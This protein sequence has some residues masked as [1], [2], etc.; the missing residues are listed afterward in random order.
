MHS[1]NDFME[2]DH[3]HCDDLFADVE[4]AVASLAWDRA[5]DAFT[6]FQ[7][8]MQQ[9]FAAEEEILFPAFVAKSGMVGGPTQVMQ[10]EHAQMNALLAQAK[11]A[12]SE[13]DADEY[14][15]LADTLLIMMQQHNMKEEHVLYPMCDEH[16][17]DQ[18]DSLL[19]NL[20][21]KIQ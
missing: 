13:R 7:R 20:Q 18:V 6:R 10:E 4:Q 16:L 19:P 14:E 3:R 11:A 9:H 8:A 5:T 2:S 12:I 17:R 1:I 21:H 15:G